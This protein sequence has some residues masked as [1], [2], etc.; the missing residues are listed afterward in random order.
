MAVLHQLDVDWYKD[1]NFI[2]GSCVAAVVASSLADSGP[3]PGGRGGSTGVSGV[4]AEHVP[5]CLKA[6][7]E[8]GD[9]L[10]RQ[11]FKDSG[12]AWESGGLGS[13]LLGKAQECVIGESWEAA[14]VLPV[15]SFG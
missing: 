1:T 6:S 4:D 15:P 12:C 11:G 13:L 9:V 3:T 7:L 10:P 14:V 2:I 5:E 8:R